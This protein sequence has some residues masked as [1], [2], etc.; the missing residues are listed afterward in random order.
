MIDRHAPQSPTDAGPKTILSASN[1]SR[2]E[3]SILIVGFQSADLIAHCISA[4]PAACT[5]HVAEILIV[6]NGDGSTE[7]FVRK[8]FPK[9]RI[10]ASRGNIGFAAGN[11][12]LARHAKG[13]K[14]LLLNPDMVLAPGA[15]DALMEGSE[16]YPDAAA[17][18]GVTVDPQGRLDTGNFLTFPT[19]ME[20]ASAAAGRSLSFRR[21]PLNA[22]DD[23]CVDVLVGGLMLIDRQAWD[24]LGGFD[25]R[26]F[27]YAEEIDL[28][29][30]FSNYGYTV[31]RIPEAR[32]EHHASHW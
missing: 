23:A 16:R 32:G 18:G 25:E 17:W 15:I 3:L 24:A 26:Y 13:A 20:L 11:N 31:W 4:I 6:D 8:S 27:L 7:E 21:S 29:L 2:I 10:V 14:L 22:T 28:F 12:W 1:E 9:V 5:N 19:L 30:R